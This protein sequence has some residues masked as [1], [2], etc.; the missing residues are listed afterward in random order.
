MSREQDQRLV[1]AYERVARG[2]TPLTEA[3]KKYAK[4]LKMAAK[5]LGKSEKEVLKMWKEKT[6]HHGGK[7]PHRYEGGE[8]VYCTRPQNFN[9]SRLDEKKFNAKWFAVRA[10]DAGNSV[11]DLQDAIN[12][13]DTNAV[14]A[15][16]AGIETQ[17][18]VMK[19][20]IKRVSEGRLD[21]ADNPLTWGPDINR[22]DPSGEKAGFLQMVHR[23][24]V[25]L[26]TYKVLSRSDVDK[27]D[28]C[29]KN[30]IRI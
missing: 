25:E 7:T 13:K 26:M 11:K 23:R 14:N 10:K 4:Q 6:P 27:I 22:K 2:E 1:E 20:A 21:E 3:S 28:K 9:E 15:S 16:L 5:E 18:S 17:L 8:C 24:A 29:M 30:V 12:K 19:E